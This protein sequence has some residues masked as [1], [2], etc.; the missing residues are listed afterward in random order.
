MGLIDD[1]DDPTPSTPEDVL[2]FP[3]EPSPDQ[4][5]IRS[6]ISD[7]GDVA[8]YVAKALKALENE[9]YDSVKGY[10]QDIETSSSSA[11]DTMAKMEQG[12]SSYDAWGSAWREEALGR[13]TDV[14]E[15][16]EKDWKS[17]LNQVTEIQS[18][19]GLST[20]LA[21]QKSEVAIGSWGIKDPELVA[22]ILAVSKIRGEELYQQLKGPQPVVAM[23]T[24]IRKI[25]GEQRQPF[26]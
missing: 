15:L 11:A 17:C 21:D 23:E 12:L 16:L 26:F 22:V 7:A 3:A 25:T 2:G 13:S 18:D 8:K 9:D 1:D 24:K 5:E 19:D 4:G 6:A 20:K 14:M 10:L